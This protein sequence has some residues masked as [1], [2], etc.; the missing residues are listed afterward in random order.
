MEGYKL[1]RLDRLH[2]GGGGVCVY[3]RNNL[4]AKVL[5]DLSSI[6]ERNFHQLWISL[7]WKKTKS[8]VVCT[9]YRP[10]DCPLSAFEDTL[11]PT[12][13]QALTLNKPIVILGDLNC[14]IRKACAESRALN[15]FS[16]EMNLQQLIKNPTI[17]T[18]TIKSLLNVILISCPQSVHSSGVINYYISDHL[19]VFVELK[20]K[21]P[22]PLPLYINF[23]C[24]ENQL[25]MN[26]DKTKFML[27]AT[28]Q[29][30]KRFS[31]S[32]VVSFLGKSLEPVASA[33][34]LGVTLDSHLTYDCHISNVVSSC[35]AKLCQINRVKN[36]FDGKTLEQLISSLVF[37]KMLYCSTVWSNT[38]TTNI[39]KLQLVQNF[40][41][42][43]VT[44]TR[45]FDHVTPLLHELNWLSVDQLLFFRATVMTYKC[46]NHLAPSYLSSK[47]VKR[48][49]IHNRRTRNREALQIPFFRSA[50]LCLKRGEALEQYI[51]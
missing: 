46:M 34:D 12:Y 33:K 7:Q 15:N 23:W 10:D 35:V 5:K 14:D 31:S 24:C 19:P 1:S 18:V 44:K 49:D 13:M 26:P 21:A 16:S 47:F 50:V 27:I 3:T 41:C 25:L 9:T 40:A 20:V 29:L 43:I 32:P 51:S 30:R 8:I 6:S 42:K 38:S 28:R 22:K 37:S 4:K 36:S 45:K 39:K 2:M 48:S 17:I 11:K